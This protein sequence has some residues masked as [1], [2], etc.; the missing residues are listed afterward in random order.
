MAQ[1]DDLPF[2]IGYTDPTASM[3]LA[4]RLGSYLK[5]LQPGRRIVIVCVGSDR[6]TGD[7]L[8]PLAGT[9]LCKF[10]SSSLDIF[11]TLEKPVHAMN[12]EET[13]EQLVREIHDPFIIAIDACLG[14]TANIGTIHIGDGP[15]HPGAG[16]HK[17]L[18]PIGDIHI[19]GVVNVGGILEYLVLQTTRLHLVMNMANLIARSLFVAVST[20]SRGNKEIEIESD[21]RD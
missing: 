11:G 18:T 4:N 2:K 1:K 17:K 6:S 15:L 9:A 13:L 14:S 3:R 7:S 5:K 19:T 16:V 21:K 8:G 12:L 10:R 20:S